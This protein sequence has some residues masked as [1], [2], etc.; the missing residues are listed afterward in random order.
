MVVGVYLSLWRLNFF[1]AWL[2]TWLMGFVLPPL[3]TALLAP[4]AIPPNAY[5]I[6]RVLVLP[7]MMQVLLGGAA[8]FMLYRNVRQRAFVRVERR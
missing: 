3:M 2:L 7:A 6:S 5:L 1:L 4:A 8:W